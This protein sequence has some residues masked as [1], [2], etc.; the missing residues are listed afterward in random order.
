MIP[1]RNFR[2]EVERKLFTHN[3]G[4]AAL[5]YIGYIKGHTYVSDA[6][7]DTEIKGVFESALRETARALISRYP[8]DLDP[9]EHDEVLADVMV[10]FGNPMLRDTVR[11]VAHDPIRKLGP[12]D[13]LIG[14]AKLCLGE[15]VTP[16]NIALVC[17]AALRYDFEGDPPAVRLQG[18]I[19]A[20]GVSGA[21]AE[22]SGTEPGGRLSRMIQ[23]GYHAVTSY[24]GPRSQSSNV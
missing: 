5:G 14:S 18:L 22:I 10:R 21:L 9:A 13:R 20:K 15:G 11:R 4:H 12:D 16:Q 23:E 19:A 24:F 3:L 17:G 1:V 8:D 6:L 2:A 7:Q